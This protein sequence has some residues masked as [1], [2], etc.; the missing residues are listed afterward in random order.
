MRLRSFGS[1]GWLALALLACL[2]VA[3]TVMAADLQLSPASGSYATGQTFVVTVQVDP[4]GAS[5]NAVEGVISFDTN[6]LSLTSISKNGSALS[7]WTEDPTTAAGAV[8]EANSS[9]RITFGGGNPS[10]F[11]SVSN[12]LSLTFRATGEGSA[13]VSFADGTVLQADATATEVTDALTGGTYTIAA[14]AEPEP[15]PSPEPSAEEAPGRYRV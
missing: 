13:E 4:S 11:S 14:A 3:P 7:L 15:T 9:G 10:P 8:T 6:L 12:L 1:L 5:I 2:L